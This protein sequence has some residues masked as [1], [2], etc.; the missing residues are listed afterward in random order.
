MLTLEQYDT[1]LQ[2]LQAMVPGLGHVLYFSASKFAQ[3]RRSKG[4]NLG[5]VSFN[6]SAV[7]NDWTPAVAAAGNEGNF[8]RK[9]ARLI[10]SAGMSRMF[11]FFPGHDTSVSSKEWIG[12][13]TC[14]TSF[15]ADV[16][17]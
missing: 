7:N 4:G 5:L 3:G 6:I 15:V 14:M 8:E 2:A 13:R 10:G 11:L 12:Q 1:S 9:F 17:E 16:H